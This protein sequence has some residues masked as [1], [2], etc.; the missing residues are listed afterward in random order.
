MLK[1]WLL[2]PYAMA[3]ATFAP[4]T[5]CSPAAPRTWFAA[6]ANRK[7]PDAPIGLLESTPPLAFTGNDPPS[8]VSSS[9]IMRQPAPGAAMSWP[10]SQIASCHENGTYSSAMSIW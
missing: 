2:A 5:W 3:S 1:Y 7:S 9:S 6:S 8:A 10:S 4:S